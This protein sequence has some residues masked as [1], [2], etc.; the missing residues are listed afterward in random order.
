M[1]APWRKLM[2]VGLGVWIGFAQM[3]MAAP[4]QVDVAQVGALPPVDG[5]LDL[6]AIER[7]TEIDLVRVGSMDRAKNGTTVSVMASREGLYFAFRC[8]DSDPASI[9]SRVTRENG[10]VFEDDSV[11]IFLVPNMEVRANNYFHFSV[12]SAGVRYSN[13]MMNDRPVEDWVSATRTTSE[14]WEA[15]VFIPYRSFGADLRVSRT[16]RGNLARNRPARSPEQ[17]AELTAWVDPGVSLHNYRRFGFYRILEPSAEDANAPIVS[18]VDVGEMIT[19][20]LTRTIPDLVV[21]SPPAAAAPVQAD[22]QIVLR[23]L[24]ASSRLEATREIMVATG[25]NLE[26]VRLSLSQLPAVVATDLTEEQA[27]RLVQILAG[28]G[29]EAQVTK[30]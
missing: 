5:V 14:G 15:E 23:A 3:A 1:M 6:A 27:T 11:Q 17:R 26:T 18:R 25:R 12:N 28:L 8:L 9:R 2:L 24:P 10:A 20:N 21:D 4:L 30:K 22:R 16:M 29:A 19:R 7:A 13:R